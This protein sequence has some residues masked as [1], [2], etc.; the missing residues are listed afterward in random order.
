MHSIRRVGI[1]VIIYLIPCSLHAQDGTITQGSAVHH[2]YIYLLQKQPIEPQHLPLP[3][4]LA[5]LH[6]TPPL[7]GGYQ[8]KL[9]SEFQ[10]FMQTGFTPLSD[11]QLS[12]IASRYHLSFSTGV[13][14]RPLRNLQLS[15]RFIKNSTH[16]ARYPD[17]ISFMQWRLEGAYQFNSQIA[18][19]ANYQIDHVTE[20]NLIPHEKNVS[21]GVHYRF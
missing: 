18:V 17:E 11:Q 13:R 2:W 12:D 19:K 3:L 4:S 8:R 1:I 15:S 10:W 14:Y 20:S 9:I 16:I 21:I 7:V 6:V 5:P